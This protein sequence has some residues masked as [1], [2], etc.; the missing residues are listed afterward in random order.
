MLY[1]FLFHFLVIS[2]ELTQ[3]TFEVQICFIF[4]I[5][6][7]YFIFSTWSKDFFSPGFCVMMFLVCLTF[8]FISFCLSQTFKLDHW[9]H[10]TEEWVLQVKLACVWFL[11]CLCGRWTRLGFTSWRTG[12][13][14]RRSACWLEDCPPCWI[15]RTTSSWS[16]NTWPSRVSQSTWIKST[17]SLKTEPA[18]CCS[19]W[20]VQTYWSLSDGATARVSAGRFHWCHC[21]WCE[22]TE[23]IYSTTVLV[24]KCVSLLIG[25]MVCV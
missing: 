3:H 10:E 17:C 4:I 14:R 21:Q 22:V 16:R 11:R 7:F 1:T 2:V 20:R 19:A 15:K 9:T 5:Y 6:Y 18:F 23:Y 24:Y 25:W 12:R 8:L 13:E